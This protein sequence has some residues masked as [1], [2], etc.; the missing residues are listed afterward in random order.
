M[1][2]SQKPWHIKQDG[3]ATLLQDAVGNVIA[4]FGDW[5]DAEYCL[6]ACN[7][8]TTIQ[9]LKLENCDLDERN[10]ELLNENER[11]KRL[12]PKQLI[13]RAKP[14]TIS[15][16]GATPISALRYRVNSNLISL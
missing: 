7:E 6:V 10:D 11:L 16:S 13:T 4:T 2:I 3:K 1:T 9:E 15:R 8:Q 12:L 14:R 5:Q